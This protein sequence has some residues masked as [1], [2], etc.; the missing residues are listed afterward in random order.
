MREAERQGAQPCGEGGHRAWGWQTLPIGPQAYE[1]VEVGC[2]RE[3]VVAL[4]RQLAELME[5]LA[6]IDST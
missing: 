5:R 3:E 2:L 1:K 6:R 4:R